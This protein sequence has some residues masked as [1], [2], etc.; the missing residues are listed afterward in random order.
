MASMFILTDEMLH[1]AYQRRRRAD[2][3]TSFAQAMADPL[4]QRLV[5]IEAWCQARRQAATHAKQERRARFI[6]GHSP[7]GALPL[8]PTAPAML[9]AKRLASGERADD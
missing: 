2:W 7:K 9:D 6:A 8:F 3:P 1:D 5:R 4:Y